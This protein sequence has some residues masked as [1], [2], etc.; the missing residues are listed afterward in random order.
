MHP[1]EPNRSFAKLH[2]FILD[3]TEV[4]LPW[5]SPGAHAPF[6]TSVHVFTARG[7]PHLLSVPRQNDMSPGLMLFYYQVLV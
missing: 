2:K 7:Q 1:Q 3:I 6:P 5:Q 4:L